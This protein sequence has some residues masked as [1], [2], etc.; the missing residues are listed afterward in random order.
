MT[1][2]IEYAFTNCRELTE[3]VFQGNV[4][5]I[6]TNVFCGCSMLTEIVFNAHVKTID[7]TTFFG[8]SLSKEW[9]ASLKEKFNITVL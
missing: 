1:T 5:T 4:G 3:V 7:G 2:I 8:C 6:G 9:K